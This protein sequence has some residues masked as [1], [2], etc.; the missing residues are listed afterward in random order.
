MLLH[1]PI[2]IMATLSPGG[3]VNIAASGETSWH[4]FATAMVGA[5]DKEAFVAVAR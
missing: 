3:I 5:R 4:C 1:L 2:A